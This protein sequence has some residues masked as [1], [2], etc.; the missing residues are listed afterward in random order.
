MDLGGA[1]FDVVHELHL[2]MGAIHETVCSALI[3]RPRFFQEFQHGQLSIRNYVREL[4]QEGK[5]VLSARNHP[6]VVER[7]K[8][9][10]VD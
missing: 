1:K 5:K 2:D 7:Y 8:V 10:S 6:L 3:Q 4:V 9:I